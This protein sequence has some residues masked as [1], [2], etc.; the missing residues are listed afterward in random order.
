MIGFM[1]K[2]GAGFKNPVASP[3]GSN[4]DTSGVK[5][6]DTLLLDFDEY[7]SQLRALSS[8]ISSTVESMEHCAASICS[9]VEI[10]SPIA[11]VHGG[12]PG[13]SSE[14]LNGA[15]I[16][17]RGLLPEISKAFHTLALTPLATILTSHAELRARAEERECALQD[18]ASASRDMEALKKK[19]ASRSGGK[20]LSSALGAIIAVPPSSDSTSTAVSSDDI[21]MHRIVNRLSASL[22]LV[23]ALEG[24]LGIEL[25]AMGE[26]RKLVVGRLFQGVASGLE[27][28]GEGAASIFHPQSQLSSINGDGVLCQ[29]VFLSAPPSP[30]LSALRA[31]AQSGS[32]EWYNEGIASRT[33][34][35][36]LAAAQRLAARKF[37]EASLD[38]EV[39]VVYTSFTSTGQTGTEG[40]VEDDGTAPDRLETTEFCGKMHDGKNPLAHFVLN[41]AA[42]VWLPRLVRG[43]CISEVVGLAQV[44]SAWRRAILVNSGNGF[45][46]LRE[47]LIYGGNNQREVCGA[48]IERSRLGLWFKLLGLPPLSQ[49]VHCEASATPAGTTILSDGGANG[50]T[51]SS[52]ASFPVVNSS[53]LQALIQLAVAEGTQGSKDSGAPGSIDGMGGGGGGD[54]SSCPRW[55]ALIDCDVARSY[56]SSTPF[57]LAG[58]I[59][60]SRRKRDG[61]KW[62]R[63]ALDGLKWG[64]RAASDTLSV[65]VSARRDEEGKPR[66][67]QGAVTSSSNTCVHSVLD[68]RQRAISFIG[69]LPPRI[70]STPVQLSMDTPPQRIG[71]RAR[72]GTAF[73]ELESVLDI[74]IGSPHRDSN[75]ETGKGCSAVDQGVQ[76]GIKSELE[77]EEQKIALC[78]L[79]LSVAAS[80]P[81]MRYTQGL[82]A[83]GRICLYVAWCGMGEGWQQPVASVVDQGHIEC[84]AEESARTS[85][86]SRFL[87]LSLKRR[88]ST[89][90]ASNLLLSLLRNQTSSPGILPLYLP[91]MGVL[92]LR[93]YQMDRLL[94]RRSPDLHANLSKLGIP[95]SSYAAPWMLTLFSNFTALDLPSVLMVWDVALCSGHGNGFWGCILSVCLSIL[96]TLSPLLCGPGANLETVLPILRAPRIFYADAFTSKK[97]NGGTVLSDKEEVH[98]ASVVNYA[99]TEAI[100]RVTHAEMEELEGNFKAFGHI[101]DVTV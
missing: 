42:H 65:L 15:T 98:I 78:S 80:E 24:G 77:A 66:R 1:K 36:D 87:G 79:L 45:P 40:I 57:G 44:C 21:K 11:A 62:K 92:R 76:L 100:Y 34:A 2:I 38:R 5:P 13:P 26:R 8:A 101:W 9:L 68:H 70:L 63:L 86:L 6:I 94:L 88:W 12:L 84:R 61:G 93:L 56:S 17:S 53:I 82:H 60:E 95:P 58:S 3:S 55:L 52:S 27:A 46:S 89:L 67:N 97:L 16:L 83:I 32:T 33:K 22:A 74:G 64:E 25:R 81:A 30:A 49:L 51:G 23:D 14:L 20:G 43:L 90:I 7:T 18:Y 91:D 10:L 54:S 75:D 41:K 35:R 47:A 19:R 4:S 37:L 59:F 69:P 73:G 31:L 29:D 96:Q 71:C 48:H 99:L 72:I 85:Y 28:F 50:T 39:A